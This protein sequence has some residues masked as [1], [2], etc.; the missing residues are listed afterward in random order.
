MTETRW[1]FIKFAVGPI[2]LTNPCLGQTE[3]ST[4]TF[5][6]HVVNTVELPLVKMM[7]QSVVEIYITMYAPDTVVQLWK[8]THE[9]G[10]TIRASQGGGVH[11]ELR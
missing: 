1:Q 11:G 8:I 6:F 5:S 7:E 3:G 2:C 4:A 10:E 9:I